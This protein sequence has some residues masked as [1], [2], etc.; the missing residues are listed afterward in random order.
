MSQCVEYPYLLAWYVCTYIVF[1]KCVVDR[2][3]I[4][5]GEFIWATLDFNE[6]C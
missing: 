4:C 3:A 2:Y 6:S 1:R 5:F